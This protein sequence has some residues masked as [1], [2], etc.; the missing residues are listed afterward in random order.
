[1]AKFTYWL[2]ATRPKTLPAGLMPVIIGSSIAYSAHHFSYLLFAVTVACSLLIQII[3]NYLNELYDYRKGADGKDR[4]G[5]LRIVSAGIVSSRAMAIVSSGLILITLSL[6]MLLV[7][8]A[9]IPVLVI[10]LLSLFMAYAY[11]GGPFPLA[12]KGLGDIFVLVFFG[13]VA[14]AG[15]YYVQA[16]SLNSIVIIAGFAPGLFSANILAVNNIRDIDSD[17][18][19]CKMTLQARLGARRSVILY[20]ALNIISFQVPVVLALLGK[21]WLLLLPLLALPRSISICKKLLITTGA[22]LNIILADT[23]KLLVVYGML[24]TIAYVGLTIWGNH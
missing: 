14:T 16:V 23:G 3:T 2:N 12:Y 18:K 11:T 4:V 20:I 10:G 15:T 7:A 24:Q 5:P 8:H 9:G 6:G 19:I 21:H 1:M 17:R 22:G 13:L